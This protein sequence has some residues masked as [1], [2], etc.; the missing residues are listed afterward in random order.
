MQEE[1]S[2]LSSE[3]AATGAGLRSRVQ[4]APKPGTHLATVRSTATTVASSPVGS[5]VGARPEPAGLSLYSSNSANSPVSPGTAHSVTPMSTAV[6]QRSDSGSTLGLPGA[7]TAVPAHPPLESPTVT[8]I[9]A[10]AAMRLSAPSSKDGSPVR[11]PI[12]IG[13]L[14]VPQP[15]SPQ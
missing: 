15:G 14:A 8:A 13:T 1:G 11:G 7:S 3:T 10:R 12:G 5:L 6:V 4:V 2:L 9:R